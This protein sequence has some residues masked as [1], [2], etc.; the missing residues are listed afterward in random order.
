MMP[1]TVSWRPLKKRKSG[2]KIERLEKDC[3]W[4]LD[5]ITLEVAQTRPEIPVKNPTKVAIR[6][7]FIEK[8]VIPSKANRSIRNNPNFEFPFALGFLSYSRVTC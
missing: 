7:G 4:L 6:N 3:P 5:Q 8:L 2:I 1:A